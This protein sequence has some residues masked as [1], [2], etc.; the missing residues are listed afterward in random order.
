MS[1]PE[2]TIKHGPTVKPTQDEVAKK[3]YA[4][5]VK[6]GRPSGHAD[7]NG[8]DAEAQL[9]HADDG[10]GRQWCS[11]APAAGPVPHSP[12]A[13][14]HANDGEH[15]RHAQALRDASDVDFEAV[16]EARPKA[17]SRPSAPAAV[18]E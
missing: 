11:T 15:R 13:Q 10:Q 3:A 12:V 9:R 7:Q 8:A 16:P 14:P 17:S 4:I 5:Y 2:G 6:E 1:E 18:I